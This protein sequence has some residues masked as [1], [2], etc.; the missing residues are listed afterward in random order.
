MKKT[1]CSLSILAATSVIATQ[2]FASNEVNLYSARQESL[3]LPLLENFTEDT[4]IAV[5]LITGSDDQLLRRLQ[6]EGDASPADLFITVDAGRLHRAK[7]AGVLQPVESDVLNEKAKTTSKI[8]TVK[9]ALKS[10]KK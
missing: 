3:I 6:V 8:Q 5:N 1:V 2:A 4:G 9:N 10:K 7:E